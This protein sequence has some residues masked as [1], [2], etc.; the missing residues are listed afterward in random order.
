MLSV[1]KFEELT[2]KIADELGY[3]HSF[4]PDKSYNVF[5]AYLTC[6][7]QKITLINGEYGNKDRIVIRGDYPRPI[8][9]QW[10]YGNSP[11]ITVTEDKSAA[12]IVKD[13]AR[14]F[15]PGYLE[16][17]AATLVRNTERNTEIN[18]ARESLEAVG[19]ALGTKP[20]FMNNSVLSGDGTVYQ[21][22]LHGINAHYS[23]NGFF[24][25]ELN[26]SV[27]KLLDVIAFLKNPTL[28]TI[29][30]S[31]D[32]IAEYCAEKGYT[33][34]EADYLVENLHQITDQVVEYV[35][36]AGWQRTFYEAVDAYVTGYR[37]T[38]QQEASYV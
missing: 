34:E 4:D 29:T 8:D 15:L 19:A 18:R 23:Y 2:R 17:L 38:H 9:G 26:L 31:S 20:R 12:A 13:I 25:I 37:M 24:K 21:D 16:G 1:E 10:H 14:R 36:E 28:T 32:D 3:K 7:D 6:E 22:D 30:V 33:N 35:S 11:S 27:E 5:Y